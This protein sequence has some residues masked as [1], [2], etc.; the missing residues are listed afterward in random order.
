[1]VRS[2]IVKILCVPG[3]ALEEVEVELAPLQVRNRAQPPPVLEPSTL[4]ENK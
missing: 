4:G 3:R 2:K 1:M